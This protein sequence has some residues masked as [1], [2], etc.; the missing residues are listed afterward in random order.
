MAAGGRDQRGPMERLTQI[1]FV[2][3]RSPGR[4]ATTERLLEHV[5]YGSDRPEDRRRQLTRDIRHLTD[6]GWEIAAV[7]DEGEAGRYRLVAG[8]LRL[9][10]DFSAAEQAELQRAARVAQLS[11]IAADLG[12]GPDAPRSFVPRTDHVA[13]LDTVQRAVQAH[14][15]LGFDYGGRPRQVH[16]HRVHLRTGGWYLRA[17]EVDGDD[18]KTFRLDRLVDVVLGQPGTAEVPPP[19]AHLRID[20]IAWPVDPPLVAAVATTT[21]HVPHVTS[22]FAGPDPDAVTTEADPGAAGGHEGEVVLRVPVTNRSAFRGRLFELGSR[23]RLLGPA[24][25]R[26]E[27]REHLVAVAEGRR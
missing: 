12:P 8:D 17:R 5:E 6:L 2:L 27:V 25:L 16:P 14:C 4:T 26:D 19:D 13:A 9:R 1:L 21:E 20:P 10:V 15:L 11:G 23:V 24:E 18:V 7:G 3:S 22:M